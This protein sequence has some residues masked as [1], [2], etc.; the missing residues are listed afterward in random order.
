MEIV[1]SEIPDL[2][3]EIAEYSEKKLNFIF[4]VDRSGSMAGGKM[5]MTIQ[6]LLLFLQSL[7]INSKFEIISFG[8]RFYHLS[9]NKEGYIYGDDSLSE[10]TTRIKRFKAELGGTN[11]YDPL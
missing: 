1:E 3:E 11:I 2:V 7:P 9:H 5:D 4:L 10:A 8:D 6:S